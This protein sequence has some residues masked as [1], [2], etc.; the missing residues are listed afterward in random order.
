[1]FQSTSAAATAMPLTSP[2][3][4]IMPGAGSRGPQL[5]QQTPLPMQQQLKVPSISTQRTLMHHPGPAGAQTNMQAQ[6]YHRQQMHHQQHMHHQQQIQMQVQM[7][8]QQQAI[9]MMLQQ[10]QQHQHQQQLQKRQQQQQQQR[11]Q[12][13]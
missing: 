5:Q 13:G 7:Q 11:R 12:L 4:L 10:Q 8:Q 1:M 9:T 3:R 6:L 2:D